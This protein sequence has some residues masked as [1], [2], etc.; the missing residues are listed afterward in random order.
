M[1]SH[2]LFN[3][4]DVSFIRFLFTTHTD[5]FGVAENVTIL[6]KL[7]VA[8]EIIELKLTLIKTSIIPYPQSVH[9]PFE[10]CSVTLTVVQHVL[11]LNNVCI[12]ERL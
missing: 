8:D 3:C 12:N 1:H 2:C 9:S 4:T 11:H 5:P 6:T 10:R 7:N